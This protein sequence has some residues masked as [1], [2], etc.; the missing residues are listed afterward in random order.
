MNAFEWTGVATPHARFRSAQ[1][2]EELLPRL[3]AEVSTALGHASWEVRRRAAEL[4]PRLAVG[5]WAS[6]VR[7]LLA[8]RAADESEPAVREAIDRAVVEIEARL[9]LR[10]V[11]PPSDAS[12]DP[13]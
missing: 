10:T 1:D 7:P 6:Q 4:L 2:R 12:G 3:I 5:A 11:P 9:G 13:R 8:E